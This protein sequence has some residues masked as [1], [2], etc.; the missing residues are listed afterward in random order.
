MTSFPFSGRP[1]PVWHCAAAGARP[2][3]R[4]GRIGSFGLDIWS[5]GPL[6]CPVRV[7]RN[8]LDT[9]R[10]RGAAKKK[11][12]GGTANTRSYQRA[13]PRRA[14]RD[15]SES[16][17]AIRHIAHEHGYPRALNRRRTRTAQTPMDDNRCRVQCRYL[18]SRREDTPYSICFSMLTRKWVY[19]V[20]RV[21]RFYF[22]Y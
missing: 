3:S 14:W 13:W 4:V 2:S 10:R 7:L 20:R 11:M 12:S 17:G 15:P 18:S 21:F 5:P 9:R 19:A 6:A 8:A 16:T 1:A 22:K